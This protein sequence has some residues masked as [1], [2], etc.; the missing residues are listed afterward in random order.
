MSESEFYRYFMLAVACTI[1]FGIIGVYVS[2]SRW[3]RQEE[4]LDRL[5]ASPL[6]KVRVWFMEFDDDW[7]LCSSTVTVLFA[8]IDGEP[9]E[10]R[11]EYRSEIERVSEKLIRAGV[12]LEN[13]PPGVLLLQAKIR[14]EQQESHKT[15]TV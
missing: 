9:Q 10:I 8:R 12:P 4:F 7:E 13:A 11:I 6:S 1:V 2:V 14:A 3:R 15:S 5:I